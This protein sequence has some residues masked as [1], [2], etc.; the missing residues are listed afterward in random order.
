MRLT[1][2]NIQ[3]PYVRIRNVVLA[4]VEIIGTATAQRVGVVAV[5]TQ[6]THERLMVRK[7]ENNYYFRHKQHI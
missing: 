7:S 6:R 5:V 2:L 3:K 4:A 1:S